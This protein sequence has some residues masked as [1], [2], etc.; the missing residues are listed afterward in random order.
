MMMGGSSSLIIIFNNNNNNN[1]RERPTAE[2]RGFLKR[3]IMLLGL[4]NVLEGYKTL[5]SIV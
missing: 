4:N 5:Y 1:K 3:L 2:T